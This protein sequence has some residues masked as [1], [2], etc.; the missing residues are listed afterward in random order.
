M[1]NTPEGARKA[2]QT[3]KTKYGQDYFCALGKVGGSRKVSKGFGKNRLVAQ[4]AGRKG[5]QISRLPSVKARAA[6]A[7]K[8]HRIRRLLSVKRRF[9][10]AA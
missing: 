5:G 8:G 1:S 4:A 7:G 2:V 3:L 10:D 9:G 6:A